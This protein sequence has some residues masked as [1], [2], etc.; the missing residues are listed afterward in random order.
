MKKRKFCEDE[1]LVENVGPD[2]KTLLVS[3]I[4]LKQLIVTDQITDAIQRF[5]K[6]EKEPNRLHHSRQIFVKNLY[7]A[8]TD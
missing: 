7:L 1:D 8:V 4:K 6:P 5:L 3:G 2:W